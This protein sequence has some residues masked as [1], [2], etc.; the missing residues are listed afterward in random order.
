MLHQITLLIGAIS[1][2]SAASDLIN[3]KQT[4]RAI[5]S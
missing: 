3:I 4:P 1:L 2:G 5:N